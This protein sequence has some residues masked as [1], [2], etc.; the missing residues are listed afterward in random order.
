MPMLPLAPLHAF[1]TS[2]DHCMLVGFPL[3]DVLIAAQGC[4]RHW[5]T[6]QWLDVLP[7]RHQMAVMRGATSS[8]MSDAASVLESSDNAL[9]C[10]CSAFTAL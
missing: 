3:L 8:P 9:A 5:L 4:F 7:L 2:G 10:G 1:P 6:Q